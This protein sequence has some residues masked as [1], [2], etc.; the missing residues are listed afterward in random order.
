MECESE[1]VLRSAN[2]L[3]CDVYAAVIV[4]HVDA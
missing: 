3:L 1:D 4:V 2:S